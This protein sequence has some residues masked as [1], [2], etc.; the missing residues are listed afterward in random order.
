MFPNNG[1]LFWDNKVVP[2]NDPLESLKEFSKVYLSYNQY[3]WAIFFISQRDGECRSGK[4]ILLTSKESSV[5]QIDGRFY[6][7]R[8]HTV[9]TTMCVT[10]S[11]NPE[12]ISMVLDITWG[13]IQTLTGEASSPFSLASCRSFQK[14]VDIP[15]QKNPTFTEWNN[16]QK[17]GAEM[18]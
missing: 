3:Q 16:R 12:K 6:Q 18:R 8:I 13:A 15:V 5:Y 9:L 2:M 4:K 11:A 1:Y 10:V 14:D 7:L 17:K